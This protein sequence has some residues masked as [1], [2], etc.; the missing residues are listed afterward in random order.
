MTTY[1]LPE[2]GYDYAALEPHISAKIME[3]HHSKHH[4]AYVKGANDTLEKLAA[5]RDKGDFASLPLLEKQLGFHT[6][7]HVMHSIFWKNLSPKGGGA[8]TGELA[9]AINTHFGT[10]ESFKK[11]LT[12]AAN[13]VMGSGWATLSWEPVGKRLIT[14]QLYDHQSETSIGSIPLLVFDA[15]EHAWYLQ[16]QNVKANFFEALWNVVN[17]DDV[18]GRFAGAQKLDIMLP[19]SAK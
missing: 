5:A 15:W 11:Q 18:A 10:F 13:G 3:L 1:V 8:P 6:S 9:T 14:T 17:W 16:Y 7:G 19:G 4:A 12:A 2:L